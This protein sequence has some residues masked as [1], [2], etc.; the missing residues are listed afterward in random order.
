MLVS[1]TESDADRA[2]S[3]DD[4]AVPKGGSRLELITQLID[5][6]PE[7][8]QHRTDSNWSLGSCDGDLPIQC[9]M[10]VPAG[11]DMAAV[12][13]LDMAIVRT[14]VLAE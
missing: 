3:D 2:I 7:S 10:R 5:M 14:L 13:A 12:E 8:V 1:S 9:S 4:A 6:Y 11:A